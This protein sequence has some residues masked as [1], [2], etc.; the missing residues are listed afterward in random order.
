MS[1]HLG[2]GEFDGNAEESDKSG[3][4]DNAEKADESSGNKTCSETMSSEVPDGKMARSAIIETDS[5]DSES[6]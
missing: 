4:Q 1:D 3:Q 5:K 6:S 2:G